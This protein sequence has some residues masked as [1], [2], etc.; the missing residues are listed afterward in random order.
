M[1][2]GGDAAV[3]RAA[4]LSMARLR[5]PE[6]FTGMG[7]ETFIDF[8]LRSNL[9]EMQE[10]A[11]LAL[12]LSGDAEA[13]PRLVAWLE[14]AETARAE[15]GGATVGIRN[16][17]FAAYGLGLVALENDDDA[18]RHAIVHAL[19]EALGNE[20]TATR[21]IQ[22]ACILAT[23]LVPLEFCGDDPEKLARHEMEGDKHL[24]GGTVL[25]YAIAVLADRE[26]DPWLRAHAAPAIGRLASEAP[27]DFREASFEAL[28]HVLE[29][30]DDE[31]FV[32]Q[33]AAIALG[34]M[35]DADEEAIDFQAR[36]LL[37]RLS[38]QEDPLL[39]RFALI[40]LARASSRQGAGARG[41]EGLGKGLAVLAGELARS[42]GADKG[43]AALALAVLGH[44]R[45]DRPALADQEILRSLRAN[46]QRAR[47]AEEASGLVLALGVLRDEE[48][49]GAV[50]EAFDEIEDPLFRARAALALGLLGPDDEAAE[51]MRA[52]LSEVAGK[53]GIARDAALGLRLAGDQKVTPFLIEQLARR[54][55]PEAR[56]A[57]VDA[58][59]ALRDPRAL[60][61]LGAL[62]ADAK[63]P[64][65]VRR[66]AAVAVGEIADPRAAPW[67]APFG[68]DLN[69]SLLT[70]TLVSPLGDGSGLLEM[71]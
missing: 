3:A 58:L 49:R 27:A 61:A 7:L 12:G 19:L 5:A 30:R 44:G 40:G 14:D 51:P 4:L 13:V 41:D 6:S 1:K 57:L 9:A 63:G 71:R 29:A 33:S 42:Q 34:L 15:S 18:L 32:R 60:G 55:E 37:T 69:Y 56:A 53:P 45:L 54:P 21:E 39:A 8:Y 70:W 48:S 2:I 25:S 38:K 59:A 17:A 52:F 24:C 50:R 65:L 46:L 62:L 28:R 66:A 16:R 36:A 10:A 67:S 22:V 11:L 47:T 23:G 31:G 68:L 35:A 43:W 64:S 26:L 20:R